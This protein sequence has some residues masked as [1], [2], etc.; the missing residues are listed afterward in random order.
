VRGCLTNGQPEAAEYLANRGAPL[1]LESAA[2]L[3]RIDDVKRLTARTSRKE[4]TAAFSLACAYGRAPVIDYL[5]AHGGVD[6]ETELRSHGDGHTGLHIA[7]FHGQLE[8]VRVLLTHGAN[9]H[10][11]DKTWKTP[12]L[13]WALTGW[14]RSGHRGQYH[15]VVA[16]LVAS[17]ARVTPEM[18]EW[19]K[20][21][22]DPDMLAALRSRP[23]SG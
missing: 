4:V 9:I 13:T 18:S 7:A 14:Q 8:A 16:Q 21:Q 15:E 1:D 11:I 17:G 22:L 12:P 2:G 10:A 20:A 19:E 3:G 6:V 5:L 23:Q